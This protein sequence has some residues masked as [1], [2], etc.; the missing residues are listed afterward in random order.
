MMSLPREVEWSLHCENVL[1]PSPEQFSSTAEWCQYKANIRQIFDK[2]GEIPLLREIA[3]TFNATLEE[4]RNDWAILLLPPSQWD[5]LVNAGILQP[6]FVAQLRGSMWAKTASL[7]KEYVEFA[8]VFRQ[9]ASA[10]NTKIEIPFLGLMQIAVTLHNKCELFESEIANQILGLVNVENI[11]VGHVHDL[12]NSIENPSKLARTWAAALFRIAI[13]LDG[14]DLKFL[15]DIWAEV[16]KGRENTIWL[17]LM[18]TQ[19]DMSRNVKIANQLLGLNDDIGLDLATQILADFSEIPLEVSYE[20]S[21]RAIS[22]LR[23]NK[24]SDGRKRTLVRCLLQSKP[25]AE[26]VGLYR[27]TSIFRSIY[28]AHPQV[29]DQITTR[30]RAMPQSLKR[31]QFPSLRSELMQ[32]LS[33]KENYDPEICAA[34]ID[35]LIQL[36][37][38]SC[39]PMTESDW[40][41]NL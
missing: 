24:L 18:Y 31:E 23:H 27:D 25:T 20:I 32:L 26:E 14:I 10:S 1:G 8:T 22:G 3:S 15:C 35:A 7:S 41:T 29:E 6:N 33:V 4:R 36:D 5:Y 11:D 2:P 21:R 9:Y 16:N 39:A 12:I 19:S 37:V 40:Q 13:R 34:T 17:G 30:L 38:L 28:D